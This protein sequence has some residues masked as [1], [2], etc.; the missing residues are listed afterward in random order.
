MIMRNLFEDDD[1]EL[2][3]AVEVM[4]ENSI[5]KTAFTEERT[6]QAEPAMVLYLP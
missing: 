2:E 3:D 4:P 6:P 5:P 1:I